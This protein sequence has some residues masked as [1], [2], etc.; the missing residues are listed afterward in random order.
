MIFENSFSKLM[1]NY[2]CQI[3]TVYCYTP[4]E[5]RNSGRRNAVVPYMTALFLTLQ[6]INPNQ[7]LSNVQSPSAIK[8]LPI[9][10]NTV[11]RGATTPIQ[12]SRFPRISS[13]RTPTVSDRTHSDTNRLLKSVQPPPQCRSHV[14]P[15][16]S[17]TDQDSLLHLTIKR[18]LRTIRVVFR[19]ITIVTFLLINIQ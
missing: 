1:C 5:S 14:D 15:L 3:Q 13:L 19:I 18:T 17:L 11:R 6:P 4:S 16:I 10:S 7:P 9:A 8:I 2:S 12:T